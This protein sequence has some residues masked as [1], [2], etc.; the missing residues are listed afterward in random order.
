MLTEGNYTILLPISSKLG[1]CLNSFR[2]T[3]PDAALAADFVINNVTRVN[4]LF[5]A[6]KECVYNR[7]NTTV[8]S[9]CN[10]SGRNRTVTQGE[11]RRGINQLFEDCGAGGSFNGVHVV[12]N[13]TF[14][15]YGIHAGKNV[16]VPEGSPPPDLP[17]RLARLA[18]QS[19]PPADDDDCNLGVTGESHTDCPRP[20]GHTALADGSCPA[21]ITHENG[22]QVYCEVR[23]AGFL[24]LETRAPDEWG[25]LTAAGTLR[26]LESGHETSISSGFSIGV[27]G[28]F[29]DSIGAGVSY[30]CKSFHLNCAISESN[31]YDCFVCVI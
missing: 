2:F 20:E 6:E 9:L 27:D 5:L 17:G 15:A 3:K 25:E 10:G 12:N 21:P 16:A 29:K 24:G 19:V 13:L 4:G 31:I 7:A 8:V 22:C 28:V 11:V 14:A 23:R 30:Q 26:N 1:Q 18:R